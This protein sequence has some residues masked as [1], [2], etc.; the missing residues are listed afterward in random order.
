MYEA[1]KLEI[2]GHAAII[3]LNRPDRLNAF[4]YPMIDEFGHA[5][6]EAERNETV[7]GIIITGE[8]RGFCAGV[9]MSTL[10]TLHKDG[11]GSRTDELQAT[12]G[13]SE[14]GDNFVSGFTYLMSIRKPVIAAVNGACVGFGLSVA[15]LCDMRFASDNAKFI[16]SFS[17]RGLVA[18]HGQSWILPRILNPS[19][20]LDLL[21][22]S[23]KLDAAE[24]AAIG[25]VDRVFSPD[26]LLAE[27]MDYIENLAKTTAPMS[28]MI[29][30][31]QVYRHLNMSLGEAMQETTRL[32]DESMLRDDFKEGIASFVEKRLPKF[33]KI[34]VE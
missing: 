18:E 33:M 34:A 3:T 15:L 8:G 7:T 4:T 26:R 13:N 20:A 22:S 30:K 23:R 27:S 10:D 28:L 19:R 29:I 21:W 24:A 6:A 9:D 16:T 31:R 5:I 11:R 1:I 14:M 2:V 32:T 25:M 17:S 12:P